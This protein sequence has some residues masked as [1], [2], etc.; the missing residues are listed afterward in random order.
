M[1]IRKPNVPPISADTSSKLGTK[2]AMMTA[3]RV[4]RTRKRAFSVQVSV[5]DWLKR[6]GVRRAARGSTRK[7]TS[8]VETMGAAL[9]GVLGLEEGGG[10]VEAYNSGNLVRG[11]MAM[12]TRIT[13]FRA[14]G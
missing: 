12:R 8:R 13:T 7:A 4:T 14:R 11:T 1:Q 10:V 2:I 5:L 3:T 6:F 9:G